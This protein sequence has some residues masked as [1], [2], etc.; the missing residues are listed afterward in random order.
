MTP[1]L[2]GI[3]F[4]ILR[5]Q[6]TRQLS[7]PFDTIL[8]VGVDSGRETMIKKNLQ[9]GSSRRLSVTGVNLLLFVLIRKVLQPAGA[10]AE[11]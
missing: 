7:K 2:L 4:K 10:D 5:S 1:C 6:F 9:G 11:K 3:H 8:P